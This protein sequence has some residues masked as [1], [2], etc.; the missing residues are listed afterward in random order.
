MA[1]EKESREWAPTEKHELLLWLLFPI[2]LVG[3]HPS[4]AQ[5]GTGQADAGVLAAALKSLTHNE[6]VVVVGNANRGISQDAVLPVLNAEG[7]EVP[8]EA[9]EQMKQR[10]GQPTIHNAPA[11]GDYIFITGAL[12]ERIFDN[13]GWTRFHQMFPEATALISMSAP[14]FYDDGAKAV[15]FITKSR[16]LT[17]AAGLLLLLEVSDREWKVSQSVVIV[18]S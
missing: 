1:E 8:R 2:L 13:G 15:V 17:S 16:G 18:V 7:L 11:S 5:A 10:A 9:L 6:I 14:G 12:R 3:S 4:Y